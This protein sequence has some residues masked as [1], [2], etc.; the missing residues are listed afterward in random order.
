MKKKKRIDGSTV[1]IILAFIIMILGLA[2]FI[3]TGVPQVLL[4]VLY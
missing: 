4:G 1:L 3:A 2:L